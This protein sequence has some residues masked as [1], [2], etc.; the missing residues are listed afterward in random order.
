[1]ICVCVCISVCLYAYMCVSVCVRVCMSVCVCVCVGV[2]V[3]VCLCVCPCVCRCVSAY[4]CVCYASIWI[5]ACLSVI[6][7][8]C[9]HFIFSFLHNWTFIHKCSCSS[10]TSQANAHSFDIYI[11]PVWPYNGDHW[12]PVLVLRSANGSVGILQRLVVHKHDMA[13]TCMWS[14]LE[15]LCF[16]QGTF[17]GVCLWS[18]IY[19]APTCTEIYEAPAR[20]WTFI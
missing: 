5:F 3:R 15:S 4:V 8:I 20:A 7:L 6:I 2:C 13:P 12:I 10:T 18:H 11:A 1:M 14:F 17:Y 9:L 16:S 19:I